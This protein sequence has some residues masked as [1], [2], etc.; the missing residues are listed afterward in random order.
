VHHQREGAYVVGGLQPGAALVIVCLAVVTLQTSSTGPTVA[1]CCLVGCSVV[2]GLPLR[3]H[4][5]A[6][7]S[8]HVMMSVSAWGLFWPP[9][10]RPRLLL[11]M[12]PGGGGVG[13]P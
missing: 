8:W 5:V 3:S 11:L 6:G 4:A 12:Q 2:R 13:F 7:V 1:G 9:M 10:P